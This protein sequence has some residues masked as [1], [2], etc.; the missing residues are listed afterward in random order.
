MKFDYHTALSHSFLIYWA[1]PVRTMTFRDNLV[2]GFPG[3][4]PTAPSWDLSV[5]FVPVRSPVSP[6]PGGCGRVTPICRRRRVGARR[7]RHRVRHPEGRRGRRASGGPPPPNP[8]RA[9]RAGAPPKPCGRCCGATRLRTR[10][11]GRFLCAV[12]GAEAEALP[13]KC[14]P[15]AAAPVRARLTPP[16][17]ALL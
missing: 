16:N 17:S 10:H 2:P 4:Q 9:V 15:A 12:Y 7:H 3:L 5:N 11:P 1:L 6:N 13:R 8:P 14:V